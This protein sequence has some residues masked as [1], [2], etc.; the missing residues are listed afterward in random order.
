MNSEALFHQAVHLGIV[1]SSED[2]TAAC[3]TSEFQARLAKYVAL[4]QGIEEEKTEARCIEDQCMAD[5]QELK[6]LAAQAQE[7][8]DSNVVDLDE[9]LP[10]LEAAIRSINSL[11][12]S[13]ICEINSFAKPPRQVCMTFEAVA[14]LFDLRPYR[15][16]GPDGQFV[17]DYWETARRSF[18]H[19]NQFLRKLLDFDKDNIPEEVIT[20]LQPYIDNEEFVPETVAKCSRACRALCM[21]V[22]SMHTYHYVAKRVEPKRQKLRE[23]EQAMVSMMETVEKRRQSLVNVLDAVKTLERKLEILGQPR[24]S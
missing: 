10:A 1:V 17:D 11:R 16:R 22:R 5:E 21:W 23:T 19:D 3:G 2:A 13:D 7:I 20:R 4:H 24:F 9:A 14:I 6:K 8:R 12:K 15:R 18:L